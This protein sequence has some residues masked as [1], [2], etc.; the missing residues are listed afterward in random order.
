MNFLQAVNRILRMEAVIMGDDDDLTSFSQTQHAAALSLAQIAIQAQLADLVA[1]DIVP[2]EL[3]SGTF[4]SV[5]STRTYQLASDFQTL[6]ELFFEELD[7]DGATGTRVIHYPGGE[8][9]LRR[10]FPRYQEEEGR[11]IWF[12]FIGGATKSV[13]LHPVPSEALTYR[14]YYQKDV[15]VSV[16]TDTIPM[17]TETESQTF[18]RMCARHFK[19]LKA[20][21]PVREQLFPQGIESDP[22]IL[23]A[24]ATLMGLLY[25]LPAKTHYG[26][27]YG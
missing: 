27:R 26:K 20:S 16:E 18:I 14:Y 9:Q 7:V 22:V 17:V 8:S 24:R 6:Q 13:G 11:P 5:A 25:P 15:N 1:S 10:D 12:Y 2:Y 4:P 3:T 19:Y 21:A 23:Q